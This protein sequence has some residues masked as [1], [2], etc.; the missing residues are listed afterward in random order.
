VVRLT[1]DARPMTRLTAVTWQ[2]IIDRR[3]FHLVANVF[4]QPTP[5][6][7]TIGFTVSQGATFLHTNSRTNLQLPMTGPIEIVNRDWSFTIPGSPNNH[8]ASAEIWE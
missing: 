6:K 2:A 5:R 7:M 4:W 8:F 3:G 1:F